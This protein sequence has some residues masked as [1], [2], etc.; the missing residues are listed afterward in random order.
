[1]QTLGLWASECCIHASL[2]GSWWQLPASLYV[3]SFKAIRMFLACRDYIKRETFGIISLV[4]YWCGK[5][6]SHVAK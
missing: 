1:M 6:P 4:I 2:K 5:L 3:I